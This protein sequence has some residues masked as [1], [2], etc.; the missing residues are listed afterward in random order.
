MNVLH[1]HILDSTSFPVESLKFPNLTK[2]AYS[3][4]AVYS[5][6][7]LRILV[8]YAK[9]RGVR[10]VVEIEMPGHGSFS[11]GMPE[12]SLSS[13]FD[14][15]NPT[16]DA[17]YTFLA[18]F[19][20]EMAS[21]FE[22]NLIYLGGDEVGFDSKCSWPGDR[23]C[24]YHCFDKDPQV[25]AWMKE[26]QVC[27]SGIDDS[28]TSGFADS[29]TL[30]GCTDPPIRGSAHPTSAISARQQTTSFMLT[31]GCTFRWLVVIDNY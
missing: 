20:S 3:A 14:V 15:L 7:D 21:V 31:C 17:T 13:C 26:H 5:L 4:N 25:A 9:S 12:L 23:V 11:A 29:R 30:M 16:K 18:E 22:D 10:I 27:T 8:Q 2:G 24:G 28:C 19:L 6:A 1:W